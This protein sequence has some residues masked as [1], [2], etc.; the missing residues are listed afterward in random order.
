MNFFEHQQ[1]AR[2]QS[3]WILVGFFIVTILIVVV[4]D[5]LLLV[6][7][8]SQGVIGINRQYQAN[9]SNILDP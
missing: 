3:R 9:V 7:L 2:K 1:K 6:L 8:A 4:I 5:A